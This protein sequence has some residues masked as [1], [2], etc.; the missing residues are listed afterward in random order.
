[1]SPSPKPTC[2][3]KICCLELHEVERFAA[4]LLSTLVMFR[5]VRPLYTLQG[6]A[7]AGAKVGAGVGAERKLGAGMHMTPETGQGLETDPGNASALGIGLGREVLN[8]QERRG[9]RASARSAAGPHRLRRRA[10]R[11]I[12][13]QNNRYAFDFQ[14]RQLMLNAMITAS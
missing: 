7:V 5:I 13:E 10:R 2:K 12:S 14:E 8:G 9:A 6:H 4:I 11:R 3:G 1:M